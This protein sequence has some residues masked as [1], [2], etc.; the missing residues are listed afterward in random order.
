MRTVGDAISALDEQ[1]RQVDEQL[2]TKLASLPNIPDP[3]VPVGAGEQD[4]QVVK[5]VG[6]IPEFAFHSQ[7]TLGPGS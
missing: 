4:N 7:S 2:T 3:A 1:L 6:A 5:T